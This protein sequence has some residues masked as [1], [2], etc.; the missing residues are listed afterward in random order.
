[1]AKEAAADGMWR[2]ESPGVTSLEHL[3][4]TCP[5]RTHR[6]ITHTVHSLAG[7]DGGVEPSVHTVDGSQGAEADVVIVSF[8]RSNPPRGNKGTRIG[9]VDDARRLNVALTRARHA[10][11][12]VGDAATLEASEGDVAALCRSLRARGLVQPAAAVIKG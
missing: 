6:L 7:W 8:V 9:F 12:M 3:S 5:S 11:V 10:L 1:M 4:G 2:A